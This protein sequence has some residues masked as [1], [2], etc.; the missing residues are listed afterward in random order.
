MFCRRIL[1]KTMIFTQLKLRLILMG[2][3]IFD[4]NLALKTGIDVEVLRELGKMF[5]SN[6]DC[7]LVSMCAGE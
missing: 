5:V 4:K 7:E 2:K 6:L 1:N 3:E